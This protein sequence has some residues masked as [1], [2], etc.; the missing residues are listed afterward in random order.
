MYENSGEEPGEVNQPK[1]IFEILHQEQLPLDES[2]H[3]L[4]VDEHFSFPSCSNSDDLN[5]KQQEKPSHGENML[6]HFEPTLNI[7][8]HPQLIENPMIF[9][10]FL[11]I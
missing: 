1:D 2:H 9:E 4:S 11:E 5:I 6:N 10:Q 8:A 3:S 7:D